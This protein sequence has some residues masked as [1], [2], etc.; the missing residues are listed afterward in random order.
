M[1]YQIEKYSLNLGIGIIKMGGI[2]VS[3]GKRLFIFISTKIFPIYLII[4]YII[5]LLFMYL[6]KSNKMKAS[7]LSRIF[8]T[9]D[10]KFIMKWEKNRKRGKMMSILYYSIIN[11]IV[12]LAILIIYS[13]VSAS[14]FDLIMFIG[15]LTGNLIG[16]LIRWSINEEKY[17]DLLNCK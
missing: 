5:S 16:L 13:L 12:L 9:D 6:I 11:S 17:H 8:Y 3:S 10:E 4:F 14:D 2:V 1:S 7:K 15:L